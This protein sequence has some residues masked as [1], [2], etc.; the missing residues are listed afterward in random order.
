M[1]FTTRDRERLEKIDDRLTTFHEKLLRTEA[2]GNTTLEKVAEHIKT[3]SWIQRG[4]LTILVVCLGFLVQI[5][6]FHHTP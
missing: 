1:L 3:C 5:S 4:V 6:V 2:Q